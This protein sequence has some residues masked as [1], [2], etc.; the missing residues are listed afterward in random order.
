MRGLS[1]T[2]RRVLQH[3][4]LTH[5]RAKHVQQE[6][7]GAITSSNVVLCDA[8]IEPDG[9]VVVIEDLGANGMLGTYIHPDVTIE[10]GMPG[11]ALWIHTMSADECSVAGRLVRVRVLTGSDKTGLGELVFE[12]H[13]ELSSGVLA[14]GNAHNPARVLLFGSPTRLRVSVFVTHDVDVLYF[15]GSWS[16]YPVSGPTD[17]AIL[18]HDQPDLGPAFDNTGTCEPQRHT[19]ERLPSADSCVP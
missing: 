11:H 8:Q 12:G 16:G 15:A 4:A 5:S 7:G 1:G 18:M 6:G 19:P 2:H 17:V 9:A 3:S 10:Q 13:L 14:I